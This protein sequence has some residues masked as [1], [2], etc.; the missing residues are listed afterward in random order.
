MHKKKTV[1]VWVCGQ[2]AYTESGSPTKD[3]EMNLIVLSSRPTTGS[4]KASTLFLVHK[5]SPKYWI[6]K[7]VKGGDS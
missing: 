6:I 1:W 5:G 4:L 3:S 2:T 7:F